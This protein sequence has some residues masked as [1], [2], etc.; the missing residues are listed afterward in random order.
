MR[1]RPTP[2]LLLLLLAAVLS[3]SGRYALA[4][5]DAA[6]APEDTAYAYNLFDWDE[7]PRGLY[8]MR[9]GDFSELAWIGD[10][11]EDLHAWAFSA[12][13]HTLYAVRSNEEMFPVLGTVDTGSGEFTAIA[14]LDA[15]GMQYV[16]GLA[17]DP[18][19]GEAYLA[20]T[21][22]LFRVDLTTGATEHIGPFD[23][24]PPGM[25]DLVMHCDGTLYGHDAWAMALA[26]IDRDTGAGAVFANH[27]WPVISSQG[28]TFDRE[29]GRLYAALNV[30]PYPPGY[31]VFDLHTGAFTPVVD[32]FPSGHWLLASPSTC[33]TPMEHEP[34]DS[35]GEATPVQLPLNNRTGVVEG[36]SA[37]ADDPDYFRLRTPLR[38]QGF[39]R[40]RIALDS[41]TPGHRLEVIGREQSNGVIAT[42][43][44]VVQ[45][46]LV[47]AQGRPFVQWYGSEQP[48]QL[49]IRVVGGEGTT[50]GYRL[51]FDS[52]PASVLEAP[53]PLR[54]GPV[55]IATGNGIDTDLWLYDGA[56]QPMPGHG[57]D[58]ANGSSASMLTRSLAVG[59]HYLAIGRSNLAN[60]L[61]SPA[62]DE[63]RDG[64]VLALPGSVLS[65]SPLGTS[66][67]IG[68]AI[69]GTAVP[70]AIEEPLEIV[71]VRFFVGQYEVE[72]NNSKAQANLVELPPHSSIGVMT[73]YDDAGFGAA[74]DY[75]LMR[76][77]EQVVPAFYRH[78]LNIADPGL[79]HSLMVRGKRQ[80]DSVVIDDSDVITQ[81][82]VRATTPE[83]HILWY[84]SERPTDVYVQ[85]RGGQSTTYDYRL[86]Y[87]VQRV[88]TIEGPELDA[89]EI[90][91]STVGLT[92]INTDLWVLDGNRQV[93]PGYGNDD[94]SSKVLQSR[95]VRDYRPGTYY[96]AI[97]DH[98]L[99]VPAR[100][101]DDEGRANPNDYALDFPGALLSSLSSTWLPIGVSIGGEVYTFEKPGP[102]GVTFI[103]FTVRGEEPDD[104]LFA[105][106][107]EN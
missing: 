5:S 56:R 23:L 6:R 18:V 60:Q 46:G 28:M 72:P 66:G 91:I 84:T 71:F 29:D 86:D 36:V 53:L 45:Q 22:H 37:S 40:Y 1:L 92:T 19:T 31:G 73:G 62:D 17:I 41:D 80:I 55:T 59:T 82:S 98:N 20:T 11:G 24:R 70:A 96:L 103:R 26:T 38:S 63:H 101:A 10:P 52:A 32:K 74:G 75:F 34:N 78:R 104:R 83:H 99:V 16:A 33:A 95:L 7:T 76:S 12:D 15:L 47:D 88:P 14:T 21:P 97:S 85:A 8:A 79:G 68:L 93:I 49:E 13:G 30:A 42:S 81:L 2:C 50:A 106:G 9:I 69:N 61:P 4:S 65:G 89:G 39:Y 58:D 77:A 43:E 100:H 25:V 67:D 3:G 64:A 51:D 35:T 105:N 27:T 54:P 90:E 107:F 48:G 102:F 87:E 94:V 57:N 44:T